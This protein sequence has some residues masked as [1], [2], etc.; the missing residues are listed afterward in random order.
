MRPDAPKPVLN[1]HELLHK[2]VWA[3][4]G[5]EGALYAPRPAGSTNG[6]TAHRN[7]TTPQVRTAESSGVTALRN[8]D[9]ESV[10]P[11]VW[12]MC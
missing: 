6:M 11:S 1:D 9:V 12:T 10:A 5:L 7:G 3:T 4:L 8:A 2:Y